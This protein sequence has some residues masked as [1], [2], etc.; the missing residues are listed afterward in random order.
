M[1]TR[2]AEEKESKAR[3]GMKMMGLKD[4]TYYSGWFILNALIVL[5]ISGLIVSIIQLDL[6]FYSNAW[7]MLF[8]CTLYGTQL[9]GFS[10][11]IVAILPSKKA[12]ATAASIMHLATYYVLHTY[13][14]YSTSMIDKSI[15]AIF[16]PNVSLGFMLDHLLH[17]E[18]TS[19]VGLTAE[20]AWMPF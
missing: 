8:M 7:L 3:E 16:V 14:G 12:S 4:S 5:W 10:L 2:L 18:I 17:C 11:T 15:V 6:F 9:F 19:G 1:V 13:K 20:T